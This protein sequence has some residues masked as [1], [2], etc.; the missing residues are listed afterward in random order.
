[1]LVAWAVLDT[2]VTVVRVTLDWDG[3]ATVVCSPDY[4][5]S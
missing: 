4:A 1:M 5:K 2:F 3:S